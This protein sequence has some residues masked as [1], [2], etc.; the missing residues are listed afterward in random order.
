IPAVEEHHAEYVHTDEQ[1]GPCRTIE[2]VHNR[3]ADEPAE[4]KQHATPGASLHVRLLHARL[5]RLPSLGRIRKA[6][7]RWRSHCPFPNNRTQN[8][9]YNCSTRTLTLPDCSFVST[10]STRLS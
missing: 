5:E 6:V 2:A 8:Q 1:H 3:R 4:H 10:T 7:C 9:G